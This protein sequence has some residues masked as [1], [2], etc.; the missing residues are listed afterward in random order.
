[1]KATVLYGPRDVRFEE[2]DL[3]TIVEA[4]DDL[5]HLHVR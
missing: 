1:M 3:S 5:S 2:R 4:T